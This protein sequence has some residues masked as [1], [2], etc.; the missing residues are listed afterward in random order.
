MVCRAGDGGGVLVWGNAMAACSHA[1][2]RAVLT[3]EPSCCEM[4]YYS[5]VCNDCGEMLNE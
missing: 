3:K 1:G 2:S 4:G 5:L